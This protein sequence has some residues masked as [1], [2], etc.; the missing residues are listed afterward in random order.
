MKSRKIISLL[1]AAAMSASVFS[2]LALTAHAAEPVWSYDG[3]TAD[4]WAD[5]TTVA[6]TPE[7]IILTDTNGDSF[8]QITSADRTQGVTYALPTQAQL[9]DDYVIE[10]DTKIH[11]GNGMGRLAQ[12]A[13]ILFAGSD[14]VKD[15]QNYGGTYAESVNE[16]IPVTLENGTQASWDTKT[17]TSNVGSGY[18]G[19][20]F[21]I[22]SRIEL[23]G[24]WIFNY[25]GESAPSLDDGDAQ[26]GDDKWVRVRAAVSDGQAT[27][28]VADAEN[29]YI[30]AQTFAAG[31]DTLNKIIVLSNRGDNN[32]ISEE[33]LEASGPSVICLDNI[34]IYSGISDTPQFTTDGLRTNDVGLEEPDPPA[35]LTDTTTFDFESD[36]TSI[37]P[38][39]Q[40]SVTTE[41]VDTADT[42]L[43]ADVNDTK[44]LKVAAT[45]NDIDK[46]ANAA[47]DISQYTEGKSHVRLEYDSYIAP[48]DDPTRVGRMIISLLENS[49]SN[50]DDSGIF[51]IGMK[52][53]RG[54][55]INGTE[56]AAGSA[57][58]VH[59]VVDIDF[60]TG[61]G[62]YVATNAV[63][64]DEL[65]SGNITTE[66]TAV[67]SINFLSWQE[68]TAYID[69]IVIQTGGELEVDEPEPVETIT[70][71]PA[72]D[73]A[74][75]GLNLVPAEA[76]EPISTY[77][78]AA[79]EE[80]LNHA[81]AGV[82]VTTGDRDIAAYSSNARGYSIYAVYD[83]YVG[84]DSSFGLT[85]A[86]SSSIGPTL[87][88]VSDETGVVSVSAI[89]DG[90][91]EV[92]A[93]ETL[94]HSTWYRVLVE[95]PQ[96]GTSSA[97]VT[98]SITYT[99]YRIDSDI[100]SNTA[101]TAV[102]IKDLSARGLADRGLTSM[103][104]DV[105]G[106]VYIDNFAVFRAAKGLNIGSVP[107]EP[108]STEPGSNLNLIPEDG[109]AIGSLTAGTSEVLNHSAATAVTAEGTTVPAYNA[110]VNVRGYSVYAAFDVYIDK[111]TT[112]SVV[113]VNGTSQGSTIY[114]A[115]N[116]RGEV[117]FSAVV[118]SNESDVVTAENTLAAGTWYRVLVEV[119]QTAVI[120]SETGTAT[121]TNTGS[122]TA[123]VY[124]INVDNP[125]EVT[126]VAA[127]LTGLSARG[128]A[129]RGVTDFTVTSSAAEETPV[130]YVDN[131]VTFRAN[132]SLSLIPETWYSYTATYD[133][134][135]L[136]NI[137][138]A[139]V[140]DPSTVDTTGSENTRVFVWN[141]LMQPYVAETTE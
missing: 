111:G 86:G 137:I 81:S 139:E 130:A 87:Q 135:V 59:I 5:D 42:I 18:I 117:T 126:E 123:T 94:A 76:V 60:A 99:V 100:P 121:G 105:T 85:P 65:A 124:R 41:I 53:S 89:V 24:N 47:L 75:S 125:S 134:G 96:A 3:S 98:E 11:T 66:S 128:L 67:N 138:V 57:V 19:A 72:S 55:R 10:F 2:G 119:P 110:E 16:A 4:G 115:A 78:P 13:Q 26:V 28:T 83:I 131:F 34:K 30:N 27:V 8:L 104:Y 92:K 68:N 35:E 141:N 74:G 97:P 6:G 64:N 17:D 50:Y 20:P 1:S 29:T 102:Q 84:V 62:T 73:V 33:L 112:F 106:S 114:L 52:D 93:D 113:P 15:T 43:T 37:T 120:D 32:F 61:S 101:E 82:A 58:W 38:T 48:N 136:T 56:V 122:L 9:S 63:T 79:T 132:G 69:N 80:V 21:S 91:N 23:L 77:V 39:T 88:L 129:T 71:E 118:G 44:A 116:D 51:S 36:E 108:A 103:G 46:Y 25:D 14:P 107:A 31:T 140:E 127:Q 12:Y 70:P 22:T 133:E 109:I 95:V 90:N 54:Y 40:N 7:R 45:S 49:P